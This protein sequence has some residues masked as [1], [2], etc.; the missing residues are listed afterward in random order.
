MAQAEFYNPIHSCFKVSIKAGKWFFPSSWKSMLT[1][2][3]DNCYKRTTVRGHSSHPTTMPQDSMALQAAGSLWE[4]DHGWQSSDW[5]LPE[6][7]VL[8]ATWT[9]NFPSASAAAW[10]N[11]GQQGN[12]SK[13]VC[14]QIL[15]QAG[16]DRGRLQLHKAGKAR[17]ELKWNYV[18]NWKS[19]RPLAPSE[20]CKKRKR[21]NERPRLILSI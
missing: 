5:I 7:K 14:K 20:H 4:S 13:G 16:C 19:E 2:V 17:K 9:E 1:V 12:S 15:S 3:G 6:K 21:K 8:F 18:L 10:Q 11:S